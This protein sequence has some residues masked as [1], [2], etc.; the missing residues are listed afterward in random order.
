M[1]RKIA[2]KLTVVYN[3]DWG[4]LERLEELSSLPNSCALI[5]LKMLDCV[6]WQLIVNLFIAISKDLFKGV[7]FIKLRLMEV[8]RL[9]RLFV[10]Q[11]LLS[12]FFA[13]DED[14]PENCDLRLH[15]NDQ[16]WLIVALESQPFAALDYY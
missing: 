4:T 7:T 10:I 3:Y 8:F 15:N 11:Y 1:C 16:I 9:K 12:V 6:G 14:F 13:F 2:T 5:H